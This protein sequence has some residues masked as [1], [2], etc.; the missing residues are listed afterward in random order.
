MEFKVPYSTGLSEFNDSPL[1][2]Y[3]NKETEY[4][5]NKSGK[6]CCFMVASNASPFS[7]RIPDLYSIGRSLK[8]A[9]SASKSRALISLS[10]STI[11][12]E[13]NSLRSLN[14]T[15][16]RDLEKTK[17]NKKHGKM[18]SVNHRIVRPRSVSHM[19]G[20]VKNTPT[21]AVKVI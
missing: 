3:P 8:R 17:P 4:L 19:N 6:Y 10:G 15:F 2:P 16:S 14:S 1:A 5:S 9:F 13:A 11:R 12:V 21:I 18:T 7:P 20:I